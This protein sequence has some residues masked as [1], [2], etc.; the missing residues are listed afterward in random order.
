M[1]RKPRKTPKLVS[2]SKLKKKAD[3]VF[4][5]FI[6]ERD[7]WTCFTCGTK[8][9]RMNIQNGHY[10]SRM[11]MSLRYDER[12]CHA[13]CLSCNMF[14]HGAMD[15]YAIKLLAKYGD[16]ILIDLQ[17]EKHKLSQWHRQ[18]YERLIERYES[19]DNS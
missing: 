2:I 12:N 8:G 19:V 15:V 13:Q 10:V 1:K 14:K 17:R 3:K 9:N 7:N 6:R 5:D 11:H 16:N 18:D 4:S